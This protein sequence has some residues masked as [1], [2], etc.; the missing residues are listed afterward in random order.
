MRGADRPGHDRVWGEVPAL[1]HRRRDPHAEN[2]DPTMICRVNCHD[3][4]YD[5]RYVLESTAHDR[6]KRHARNLG[7]RAVITR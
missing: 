2:T 3:C 6:A 5:A 7:H 4:P 1:P